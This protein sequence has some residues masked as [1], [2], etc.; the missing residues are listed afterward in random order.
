MQQVMRI[1]RTNVALK[2]VMALTGLLLFGFVVGHMLGNLQLYAGPE[3]INGYAA[4]LKSMPGLLWAARIGLLLLVVAHVV[5]ATILATRNAEA[6]STPYR[7]PKHQRSTYASRTMYW[8]GPILAFYIV[9][10]LAHL[11]FGFAPHEW[12]YTDVYSN[13]V[14][15]FQ[16]PLI[17]G[18]YIVGNLALGIHLYHGLWSLC[19]SLGLS[20][21]RYNRYR[22]MVA[23][24]AALVV[25]IGNISF[26]ISVLLGV[27]TLAS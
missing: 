15:G 10:H 22:T 12:S 17:A 19:Q 18:I 14:L 1:T 6:R 25:T 16:Q 7:K 26:P 8:S 5:C 11:T 23:T 9:Y 3:T 13:V 2:V 27:V 21:P 4:L 20:H 24:A